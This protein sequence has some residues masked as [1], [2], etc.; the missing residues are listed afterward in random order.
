M[1]KVSALSGRINVVLDQRGFNVFPRYSSG[2]VSLSNKEGGIQ[3][4]VQFVI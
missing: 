2:M 3:F 4:D 1:G